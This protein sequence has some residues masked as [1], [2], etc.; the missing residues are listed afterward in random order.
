MQELL[1]LEVVPLTN[2]YKSLSL[3]FCISSAVHLY[4]SVELLLSSSFF[5]FMNVYSRVVQ[6]NNSRKFCSGCRSQ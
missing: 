1:F 4:Y 5:S 6:Q 2:W 3:A